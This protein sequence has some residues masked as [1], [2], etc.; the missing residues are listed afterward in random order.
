MSR[1]T[2]IDIHFTVGNGERIATIKPQQ[3][4]GRRVQEILLDRTGP[5]NNQRPAGITL[6]PGP[7][8]ASSD[9]PQVCYLVDGVR[10]C[11]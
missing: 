10:V 8:L 7:E 4:P 5:F 3:E 9:G 2:Q 6:D 11:W 1:V